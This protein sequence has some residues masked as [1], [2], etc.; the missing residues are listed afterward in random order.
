MKW[1]LTLAV[2]LNLLAG[3]YG[4]LRQRAP[5]N[6][7]AQEV[8]PGQL[9][10]LP[11]DWLQPGVTS[12]ASAP[13]SANAEDTRVEGS[14]LSASAPLSTHKVAASAVAST[15]AKPQALVPKPVAGAHPKLATASSPLPSPPAMVSCMQWDGL[16]AGLLARVRA[17][18]AGLK[19]S[20]GQM[21]SQSSSS[22]AVN[23]NVRYW[24]YY[25]EQANGAVTDAMAKELKAKG[26]DNYV[27]QNDGEFK[28]AIS[29]GL[30]AKQDT[31]G[32]LVARLKSAGYVQAKIDARGAKIQ[33]TVLRFR[34][35]TASQ[36]AALTSLQHRLAPSLGLTREQCR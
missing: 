21:S 29:L 3:A 36:A 5:V 34:S 7:H 30:F 26:F 17:G 9:K 14:K 35:L 13:A 1:F 10:T 18:L 31:A 2:I 4:V 20:K 28:G 23:T 8:N 11:A 32:E 24:V 16:N 15:A 25:P 6:I 19:L 22:P 12:D 33:L 27:V